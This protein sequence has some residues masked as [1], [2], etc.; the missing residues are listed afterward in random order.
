VQ[1]AD[2]LPINVDIRELP[3]VNVVSQAEALPFAD[4]VFAEVHAIN[5][6]GFYPV[7]AE[8]A[9]V[10]EEGAVLY[11]T[12]KPG[13]IFARPLSVIEA[14]TVGY[15]LFQTK[16]VIDMH[17]FGIQKFT[18][19]VSLGTKNSITTL[20]KALPKKVTSYEDNAGSYE[21]SCSYACAWFKAT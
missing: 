12:G 7:S 2:N 8:T 20:Y 15:E 10:M 1:R 9:R 14:E 5:P 13:I 21:F 19:G 11:V 16:T 4:N 6:Y 17:K 18:S 3:G